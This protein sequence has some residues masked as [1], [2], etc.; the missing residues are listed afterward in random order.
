MTET[1]TQQEAATKWAEALRS[2]EYE[3]AQGALC[4]STGEMCCLG[5]YAKAVLGLEFAGSD[6][7]DFLAPEG[8][9]EWTGVLPSD[10]WQ[11]SQTQGTFTDANDRLG[12][13]FPEI[14]DLVEETLL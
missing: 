2:G 1:L 11:F 14:A 10:L 7:E 3:Q 6:V 4:T 12:L 13:T 9:P 8:R 5:V